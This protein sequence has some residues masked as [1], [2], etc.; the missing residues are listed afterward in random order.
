MCVRLIVY[1]SS[2]GAVAAPAL[3]PGR[4]CCSLELLSQFGN[5]TL[6]LGPAEAQLSIQGFELVCGVC[7]ILHTHIGKIEVLPDSL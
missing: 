6:D 2:I 3:I 4:P 7:L 5:V 1:L